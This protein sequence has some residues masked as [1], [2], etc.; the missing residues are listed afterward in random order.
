MV[1]KND[2]KDLL[3]QASQAQPG[4][5]HQFELK[6]IIERELKQN[7]KAYSKDEIETLRQAQKLCER[8][9]DDDPGSSA[10]GEGGI[11]SND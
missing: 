1:A 4:G 3:N 6:R 8:K 10:A 5:T 2:V 7:R 11:G 9:P